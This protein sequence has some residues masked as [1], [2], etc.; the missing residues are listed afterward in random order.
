[1]KRIPI[2]DFMRRDPVTANSSMSL[3]DLVLHLQATGV[4]AMSVVD[5]KA[6]LV[7]VVS[8]TDLFIKD[9][10]VPF[11]M[12]KV[13]TLLGQAIAEGEIEDTGLGKS[14]TV[15][16]VMTRDVVSANSKATLEDVVWLMHR[17]KISLL[18]VVERGS[19][20]GE[21]RRINVLRLIYGIPD[22]A[23]ADDPD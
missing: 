5:D 13:P 10:G 3:Y 6:H 2:T 19:L 9:K 23:V 21:V 18:P 11:S 16:E 15:A 7:G 17:K 22:P 1:M 4:R 14:V 12:E 20:V 8:E